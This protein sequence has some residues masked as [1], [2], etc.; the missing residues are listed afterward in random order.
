MDI[1]IT[2]FGYL[3]APHPPIPTSPSTCATSETLTSTPGS[4]R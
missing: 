3:H 4:G 2:S 1:H